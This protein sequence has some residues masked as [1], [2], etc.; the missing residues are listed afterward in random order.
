MYTIDKFEKVIKQHIHVVGTKV[1]QCRLVFP[2]E[3]LIWGDNEVLKYS[4]TNKNAKSKLWPHLIFPN[5]KLKVLSENLFQNS[6]PD[7]SSI[8]ILVEEGGCDNTDVWS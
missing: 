2:I 4:I 3:S 5:I 1:L 8:L 6:S 7:R